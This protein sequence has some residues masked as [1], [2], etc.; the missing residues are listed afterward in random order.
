[1]KL[2][3]KL[4]PS[5]F[6]SLLSSYV[7]ADNTSLNIQIVGEGKITIADEDIS[8]TES[9]TLSVANSSKLAVTYENTSGNKFSHWG[10]DSCDQG[11]GV[12][13]EEEVNNLFYQSVRPKEIKVADYN[14]DGHAD[15]ATISLFTSQLN[16]RLNDQ[17]GALVSSQKFT[18]PTYTSSFAQAD[19]EQDG[20][21][22]LIVVD[23]AVNEITVYL[24]DGL[25]VFTPLLPFSVD[26][27]R[28]Y[29]L[30][31]ADI[32]NDGHSDLLLASFDANI[33]APSLRDIVTS[34][35][36]ANLNWYINDG[37][38]KFS[39]HKTVMSDAAF[40]ALDIADI[41]KNGKLEII[42]T[43]INQNKLLL[44]SEAGDDYTVTSIFEDNYPYGVVFG[45]IDHD[46]LLDIFTTSYYGE[47]A[48]LLNQQSNGEFV[49]S[50]NYSG[51][52]GLTS[53]GF[54]D[55]DQNG[56]LDLVW[57]Q[58]DDS[59]VN[60]LATTSY[61]TCIVDATSDRTIEATFVEDA[62]AGE[63]SSSPELMPKLNE[64]SSGGGG[65][66]SLLL[67]L[68]ILVCAIRRRT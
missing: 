59:A 45:D 42:G 54:Y 51:T 63:G 55:A 14:G 40:F 4:I 64:E 27:A 52:G 20:D 5:I 1:M 36:G 32:N 62:T 61:Q 47:S 17:N 46:G 24:N 8:C 48:T 2:T 66:T 57:G 53:A 25:G 49:V 30:A 38:N 43:A 6:L 21:I 19:W 39:F 68:L 22:D 37:S 12:L 44:I 29:T 3:K 7:L 65:A 11:Q 16:I 56:L 15:M 13:V 34:I 50:L 58:F 33:K 60:W 35:S 31:S 10:L 41:N 28:P 18:D 26:G 9:C 23:Y 67:G